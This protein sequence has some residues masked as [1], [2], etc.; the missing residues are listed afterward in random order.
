MTLAATVA[1]RRNTL[2]VMKTNKKKFTK[3]WGKRTHF[4]LP[5]FPRKKKIPQ[6]N[7]RFQA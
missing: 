3:K 4:H 1:R 2:G 6:Y 7:G 5:V